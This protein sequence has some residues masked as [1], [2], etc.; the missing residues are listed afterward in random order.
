MR[1]N[2]LIYLFGYPGVGKNT[3]ARAIE[4]KTSYVAIQNHLISNAFRH[5]L[6]HQKP[7][8]YTEVEHLVKHHTMKAWLNFLDFIEAATPQQ[9]LIF[10][11]VLYQDDPDRVEYFEFIEQWALRQQRTLIPVRLNCA[12]DELQRRVQSNERKEALKLTDPDIVAKLVSQHSLLTPQTSDFLDIDITNLS[13]E[14]A[15]DIIIAA[16]HKTL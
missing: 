12:T 15:A 9:G 11:S 5:I 16:L 6:A 1:N 3:I 14:D 13:P 2:A 4:R 7:A 10:T 8:Q